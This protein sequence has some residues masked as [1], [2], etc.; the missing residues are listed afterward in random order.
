MSHRCLTE[1]KTHTPEFY[2]KAL[3]YGHYLWLAGHAGRSILAITRALYADLPFDAPVFRRW[4]LPYAALKWI[5]ENH[6]SDEFPGNPRI[7]F[8][9]QATRLRG[10]RQDLLRARA[11]AVWALIC[12]TR[13][14]L[15]ADHTDSVEEPTVDE[16]C[17]RLS[18][19]GHPQ[20]RVY[21]KSMLPNGPQ[22]SPINPVP[23]IEAFKVPLRQKSKSSFDN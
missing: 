20:E 2:F 6:T 21:W 9:H 14:S 18:Q 1:L 5:C 13:P 22:H 4:P 11:W 3:Q 17:Q 12:Q 23:S 10:P 19:H 16:I 8:Q 7:S 15:P